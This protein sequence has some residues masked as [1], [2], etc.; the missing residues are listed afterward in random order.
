MKNREIQII[1]AG[2]EEL[3]KRQDFIYKW[4]N[5]LN[6]RFGMFKNWSKEIN[7]YYKEKYPLIYRNDL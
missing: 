5:I 1:L 4:K 3:L 7:K 6:R 2:Q